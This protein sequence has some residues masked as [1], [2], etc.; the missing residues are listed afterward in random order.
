MLRNEVVFYV[1]LC[2]HKIVGGRWNEDRKCAG[3]IL[4]D[5]KGA[6]MWTCG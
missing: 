1:L 5:K 4:V 6:A 2:D 3:D